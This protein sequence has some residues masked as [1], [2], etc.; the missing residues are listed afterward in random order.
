L[1]PRFD[2]AQQICTLPYDVMNTEEAREMAEGNPLSFLRV[3]RPEIELPDDADPYSPE[4]YQLGASNMRKLVEQGHLVREDKPVYMFYR[5][6]M[7]NHT[8]TGLVAAASCQEYDAGI[9][10]KHELTRPDKED[11][12]TRH[13]E[14]LGAQTGA[15]FLTYRATE[16]TDKLFAEQT[17][18]TPDIDYTAKDGIR[19]S[20][21]MVRDANAIEAIEQA[22]RNVPALYVA[23]GHHR[24]A[25]ASRVAR[26]RATRNPGHTGQEPYNYFLT[27]TFPH[28]QMQIL[29]YNRAVKDL[30]GMTEGQFLSRLE[31][32]ARVEAAPA[33]HRPRR[34][35]EATMFLDGKWHLL[36][37]KKDVVPQA[38]PVGGL[39]V[40]VLQERVLTPMLAIGN[41]R[42]DKRINF[43]GGIRGTAELERLVKSGKYAVAFAL[44][45]TSVEDLMAIADA[46]G[47]MPPKSTWF[48]PKLRDAM[49]V[50]VI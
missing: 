37:W 41:P 47:L 26:D 25:A 24:S 44:Y 29:G 30:N 9:V 20:A 43:I 36:T 31:T 4:V 5:L 17:A 39:D 50:H 23:D 14:I 10:K 22:F 2:E 8:Q 46:D 18:R 35:G 45:P 1:R 38:D 13:I 33:D 16:E 3:T 40:S 48:E 27:V 28:N 12:R 11:D 7:G 32:V 19:H 49:A 6:V 21:W 34:K 15:V 42:T